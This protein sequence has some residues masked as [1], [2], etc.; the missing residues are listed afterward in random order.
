[1]TGERHILKTTVSSDKLSRLVQDS[2]VSILLLAIMFF[3]LHF[4]S[5]ILHQIYIFDEICC[6]NSFSHN[7]QKMHFL[8]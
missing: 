4:M 7:D 5:E 1:M 6:T 2:H 8:Q 3:A